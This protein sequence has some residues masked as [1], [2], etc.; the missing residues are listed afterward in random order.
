[1]Q[2][3]YTVAGY[4]KN[5]NFYDSNANVKNIN[6]KSEREINRGLIEELSTNG[7]IQQKLNII[8]IGA[9]AYVKTWISNV[10]GLMHA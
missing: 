1:M 8:L 4:I 7:Y 6:F 3:N 5:A 2:S 10:L 9:S